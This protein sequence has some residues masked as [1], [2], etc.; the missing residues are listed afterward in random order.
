MGNQD[1]CQET[2]LP[3]NYLAAECASPHGKLSKLV[4]HAMYLFKEKMEEWRQTEHQMMQRE[5]LSSLG[6]L[7]AGMAHEINNP[8]SYVNSNMYVLR[9]HLDDLF[10]LLEC[11]EKAEG[12]ICDPQTADHIRTLRQNLQLGYLKDD[13]LAIVEESREGV[14]RVKRIVNNLRQFAH[15]EDDVMEM[16]E[17]HSGLDTTLDMLRSELQG[18][19]GIVKD[20]G[21]IPMV[22]CVPAQINQV[23]MSIILNAAQAIERRGL[24]TISTGM[25]DNMVW[26]EIRDTGKGIPL[27]N[28]NHLFDPFFT[29]KP[30]GGGTGLGLSIAYGIVRRHHGRIDVRSRPNYGSCFT[31]YLPHGNQVA[32]R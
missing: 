13:I 32:A 11:Y 28:M 3:A 16:F 25:T 5:K 15:G 26:V 17:L 12:N 4:E 27:E 8:I 31:V 6:L 30:V 9:R 14:S 19:I 21:V 20:Y 24:I 22:P 1:S 18:R 23:F 29:T 10:R 7:A 2:I